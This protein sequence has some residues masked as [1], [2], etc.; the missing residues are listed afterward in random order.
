[1]KIATVILGAA[2]AAA[3]QVAS[4]APTSVPPG[5]LMQSTPVQINDKPVARVNGAVLTDRDLVREMYTI[6]PYARQHNGFPKGMEAEIRQGA[7]Q[8]IIFEE[9]VYQ[10]AQRRKMT[11]APAR[12]NK[13]MAS[14]RSQF[15]SDQEYQEYIR[16][17]C[18]GEA[19]VLRE[20]IRRS[21][22]IDGLLKVEVT[23]K[24]VVT[25]AQAKTYYDKNPQQFR[26]RETFRIQSIS[27]I[28]PKNA[29]TDALREARKRA[30]DALR[31]AKATKNYREFG[32]LAEKISDDDWHVN[33]GDRKAQAAETLPQPIVAAARKM[34]P[35]E[36]SDL[37]QFGPNYT[38]FRLNEHTSAGKVPFPQVKSQ[39]RTDLEKARVE[40]LRSELNKRLRDNAR[41]EVL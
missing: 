11:I 14:F 30:D 13:A 1:M 21:L 2:M 8:M 28:P 36:V 39:V 3:A 7:L 10:E 40:Q 18:K 19:R 12:M 23:D 5:R 4:H 24:A 27:I 25:L 17:E 20:K 31:Q 41:V 6:F 9:L 37:F 35:G 38:L 22:L 26:R 29:G 16:Q 34:K 15:S 32:L 33:M